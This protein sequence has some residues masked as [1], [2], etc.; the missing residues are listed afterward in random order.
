M[1]LVGTLCAAALWLSWRRARSARALVAPLAAFAA[2]GLLCALLF[3]P[4]RES[5]LEYL[6]KIQGEGFLAGFGVT[7]VTTVLGGGRVAGM[8]LLATVPVGA[9][10]MLV[11]R[12]EGGVLAT[13]A[14]VGPL[15][16]MLVFQ[17]AGMAYAYAR[18]LLVALPILL[19]V[20][21]WFMTALVRGLVG[22][23]EL[24]DRLAVALGT[25]LVIAVHLSGPRGPWQPD[26][27]PYENTYVSLRRLP[28]FDVPYPDTPAFYRELAR[29]DSAKRIIEA[30]PMQSRS[31]LLYR[32]YYLQHGKETV[33][34]LLTPDM[35]TLTNGPYVRVFDRKLEESSDADYLIVH[36]NLV[37]E[38]AAY[39]NWVYYHAWKDSTNDPDA[40][41]KNRH[42]VYLDPPNAI[43]PQQLRSLNRRHGMPVYQDETIRV[44]KLK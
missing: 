20:S 12:H 6:D 4:A 3:L 18:Y 39:W 11:R 21:A 24:G 34:G 27:G 37:I 31:I 29:D 44:W 7:D 30:P 41:F 9:L 32:N 13:A 35:E 38:T 14:I 25:A 5:L 17:P 23:A 40:S 36:M 43:D 16:A 42:I 22:R 10:A 1:G 26:N 8:A 33:F 28:V 19:C 15:A 2:G